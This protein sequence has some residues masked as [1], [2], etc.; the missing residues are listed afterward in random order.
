MEIKELNKWL[1][2]W[3]GAE[4]IEQALKEWNKR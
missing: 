4:S 1:K 3:I 2:N